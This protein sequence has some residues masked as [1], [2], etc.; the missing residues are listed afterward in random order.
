ME[1]QFKLSRGWMVK[2][3]EADLDYWPKTLG[4]EEDTE[5]SWIVL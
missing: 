1:V 5:L 4:N 3:M 2:K